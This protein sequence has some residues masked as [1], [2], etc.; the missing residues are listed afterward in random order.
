MMLI[1]RLYFH[2]NVL[3]AQMISRLIRVL[4]PRLLFTYDSSNPKDGTG[5]QVQR[6]LSINCLARYLRIGYLHTGVL[7][8]STHPLDPF[9]ND[10]LRRTYV[11]RLN[12]IF[13][14]EST[15]STFS[16]Q[17]YLKQ[18]KLSLLAKYAFFSLIRKKSI[19]LRINEPYGVVDFLPEC[20][21]QVPPFHLSS[22]VEPSQIVL[23][24]RRGVG[25]FAIYHDQK[26]PRESS[27]MYFNKCLDEIWTE[28]Q[29]R[30]TVLVLTD[31]PPVDLFYPVPISQYSNWVGTPGFDGENIV[32][33]G[34]DLSLQFMDERFDF[35]F[36]Y[37]GDPLEAIAF[38]SCSQY[39]ITSRSSLSYLGGILNKQ[40]TVFT[41]S[42]FWHSP[43]PNWRV[44]QS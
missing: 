1:K 2:W 36:V 34:E 44:I 24:H 6:I 41:Q 14:I 25:N 8:V 40:G 9:Q 32:V 23:H 27:Q 30:M 38:M 12:S 18:L 20:L 43:L 17:V 5:A 19:L 7:D 11:K 3:Q 21:V 29:K 42:S 31:G 13:R 4:K 10:E 15:T 28:N 22:Q 26:M 35:E 33:K 37:G 16:K 39:L